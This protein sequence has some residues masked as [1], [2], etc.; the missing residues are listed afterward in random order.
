MLATT[1]SLALGL[2]AA[3]A[4]ADVFRKFSVERQNAPRK[5]VAAHFMIGIMS[6]RQSATDYD[7]DMKK[8]KAAGIDAFA[9]NIAKDPY[10]DTQLDFAYESATNN[11]M[12]VFI[13]FDYNYFTTSEN[14]DI[15]KK[16]ER[17]CAKSGQLKVGNRCFVSSFNGDNEPTKLFDAK[18][19]RAAARTELYLVPNLSPYNTNVAASTLNDIDGA[20]NWGA[21]DSN[22]KNRAP[23]GGTNIT[24][25]Q[26]D[27]AYTGWL[28]SKTYMAP[29]SPWF[30][31][32][33][34]S[35]AWNFPGDL[36]WFNRWNEVLALA[37]PMIEIVTWN[38][39]GESH[40]IG[41]DAETDKHTDDGS[42][43]YANNMPHI[44]WLEMAEPYIAAFKAGA[45]VP[46]ISE[47][48][49]VYWYR[50]SPKAA[51]AT[52][53]GIET[54]QDSVFVVALLRSAGTII[55][56]SGV[57]NQTFEAGPGAS[58]YQI[59]MAVGKQTFTLA[60]SGVNIFSSTGTLEV[61][62]N[63]NPVNLNAFVGIAK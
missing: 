7:D 25:S 4:D 23:S 24:T 27:S 22:G 60:R 43:T 55:I 52:F 59:D 57:N 11:D 32:N 21:W 14:Q 45:R 62:N 17:Y 35:K 58:A 10:T 56:T 3:V 63:C 53:D 37:P 38:D 9:L 33:L 26:S 8:A 34:P 29:V 15:G 28:A 50:R 46:T 49:L 19:I 13:S 61:S 40:Y 12:K 2:L 44:G 30:F 5:M 39:Y 36:L 54:L 16:L 20:F 47:E 6:N 31:T 42:S 1:T 51:C 41:V 48:K 18:A